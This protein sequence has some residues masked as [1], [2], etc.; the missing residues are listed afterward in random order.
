MGEES[1]RDLAAAML[2]AQ[3]EGRTGVFSVRIDHVETLVYVH[4][5]AV[6]FVEYGALNDALG[7]VLVRTGRLTSDEHERALKRMRGGSPGSEPMRFGDALVVL[8][9]MTR[10]QVNAALMA[11]VRLKAIRCLE[12]PSPE[13]RFEE[14]RRSEGDFPTKIGRL[15]LTAVRRFEPD[16]LRRILDLDKERYPRLR[17]DA[18]TTGTLFEATPSEQAAID[19]ADGTLSA[20][21]LIAA[22]EDGEQQ[23]EA[24]AVLAA[25]VLTGA[26]QLAHEPLRAAADGTFPDDEATTVRG[27]APRTGRWFTR[28][29]DEAPAG[30]RPS[31]AP[32]RMPARGRRRSVWPVVLVLLVGVAAGAA[33]AERRRLPA[34]RTWVTAQVPKVA[35]AGRS[36]VR[37]LVRVVRGQ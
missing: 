11:Q 17:A 13:W 31:F 24:R 28:P 1:A 37:S 2:A 25:L 8:G 30:K 4:E 19:L 26:A 22:A 18:A 20:R 34:A 21:G 35:A 5:G 7:R 16:R 29:L 27:A 23:D 32:S 15:V 3:K 12:H 9:L 14:G 36:A 33:A 6:V 10:E